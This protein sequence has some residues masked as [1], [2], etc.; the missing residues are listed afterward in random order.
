MLQKPAKFH[1][2]QEDVAAIAEKYLSTLL[3]IGPLDWTVAQR[4][5]LEKWLKASKRRQKKSIKLFEKR[6][7]HLL[8]RNENDDS[9]KHV[10]HFT[11][12]FKQFIA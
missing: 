7:E 1:T 3:L 2:G 12:S 6:K 8:D 10:F 9:F 5:R 11:G 4:N